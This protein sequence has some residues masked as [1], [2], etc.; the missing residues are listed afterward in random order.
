MYKKLYLCIYIYIYIFIYSHTQAHTH[1]YIYIYR[2][3][4]TFVETLPPEVIAHSLLFTIS[5]VHRSYSFLCNSPHT[6]PYP[7]Q[8]HDN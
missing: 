7:S 4:E 3:R 5:I 2:L 6:S 1:T 8:E